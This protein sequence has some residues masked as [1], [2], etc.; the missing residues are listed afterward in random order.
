MLRGMIAAAGEGAT[1]YAEL[2]DALNRYSD[3]EV[4]INA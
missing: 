1:P 2:L 3:L 4:G